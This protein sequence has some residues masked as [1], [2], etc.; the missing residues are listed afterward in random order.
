MN[1]GECVRTSTGRRTCPDIGTVGELLA[2]SGGL[3]SEGLIMAIREE[4][5]LRRHM[6]LIFLQQNIKCYVTLTHVCCV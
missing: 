5:G 1:Y 6:V 2:K 3:N 4:E